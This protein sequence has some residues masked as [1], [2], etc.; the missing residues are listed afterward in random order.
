MKP[1]VFI[2]SSSES[3]KIAE[4]VKSLLEPD[5]TCILWYDEFFELGKCTY[6]NLIEKSIS[7]D[8]AIFIGDKDDYVERLSEGTSKYGARDNVYLE[9]GLYVGVLSYARTFFL[10]RKGCGIASDLLG[11][12]V[13]V[14][15]KV[16]DIES[17][18]LTIKKKIQYE[19]T[20]NR[21]GLLPSTGLAIGYFENFLKPVSQVV[22]E[23][24]ELDIE[25]EKYNIKGRNK[26]IEVII[27]SNISEDLYSWSKY[28]YQKYSAA[29][30]AINTNL[31]KIGVN[32][33]CD[34]LKNS[35][36]IRIFDVP[37][38]LVSAYKSVELVLGIDYI[39]RGDV[40]ELAKE[41]ELNNFI[42]TLR[43]LIEGDIYTRRH[44]KIIEMDEIEI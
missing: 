41:K 37:L 7:F 2:G 39:G 13:S 18:I 27:P 14:F 26:S 31:R 11:V 21:V 3:K 17:D 34:K 36:T 4:K 30:V 19:E 9:F 8:Y 38:T 5:C 33:D 6:H 10:I 28:I 23:I 12:N 22:Y 43:H 29:K 20:I 35:G 25:E 24:S 32:I 1:R 15:D 42:N 40:E 44:V 16:K